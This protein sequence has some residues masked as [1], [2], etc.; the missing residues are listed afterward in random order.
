MDESLVFL[1]ERLVELEQ[2]YFR[3]KALDFHLP[4]YCL[5]SETSL[6]VRFLQ[7]L[8]ILAPAPV[9]RN[10][11]QPLVCASFVWSASWRPQEGPQLKEVDLLVQE[12]VK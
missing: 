3:T 11:R 2:E 6:A 7:Q 9:R 10:S 12:P 8:V 1:L 4:L 5:Y